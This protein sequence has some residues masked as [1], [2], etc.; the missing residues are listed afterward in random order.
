MLLRRYG[1]FLPD[2]FLEYAVSALLIGEEQT[3]P[4]I[5]FC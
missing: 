2:K 3:P 5:L 1:L 4:D